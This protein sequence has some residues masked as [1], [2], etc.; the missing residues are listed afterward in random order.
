[1]S[2]CPMASGAVHLL[3]AAIPSSQSM[4]STEALCQ[5]D[6]MRLANRLQELNS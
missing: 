1:M 6:C 5:S 2:I 4:L 3:V